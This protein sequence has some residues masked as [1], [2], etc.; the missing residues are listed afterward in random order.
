MEKIKFQTLNEAVILT[1]NSVDTEREYDITANVRINN[2][3]VITFDGGT[4][5][6]EDKVICSFSSYSKGNQ[7]TNFQGVLDTSTK[8]RIINAIDIF[9]K[10]VEDKIASG[11]SIVLN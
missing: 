1:N 3:N 7:N 6:Q 5:K 10:D 11:T 9:V 8:C 4:V 2:S